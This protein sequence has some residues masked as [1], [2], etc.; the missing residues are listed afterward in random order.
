MKQIAYWM[1][2]GLWIAAVP[3]WG[4]SKSD[5]SDHPATIPNLNGAKRFELLLDEDL[6]R[7]VSSD[8]G[9]NASPDLMPPPFTGIQ[10]TC[11]RGIPTGTIN[12]AEAVT[13]A[14]C[15]DP[16]TRQTWAEAKAQ[17][18]QVGI[19]QAAYLPTA[20]TSLNAGLDHVWQNDKA[21]NDLGAVGSTSGNTNN[22]SLD[23]T[24][25]LFDFGQRAAAVDDAQ[26]TLLAATAVHD[27]TVQTVFLE[28]ASAYYNLISAQNALSIA[29]EVEQFNQ[30]TLADAEA[31]AKQDG[32]MDESEKLQAQASTEQ[33]SLDRNSSEGDLLDT[34]GRL[35]ILLGFAPVVK[36][37]VDDKDVPT[38][39]QKLAH[40]IDELI[41]QALANHPEI[42]AAQA[43][44]NAARA[45]VDAAK[46][47]YLPTLSL[48][49]GNE[50]GRDVWGGKQWENSL[51][52]QMNIPLFNR[53]RHY[54][55]RAALAGLD[56]ARDDVE[57]SRQTVALNVWTAYQS[58]TTQSTAIEH[59]KRLLATARKLLKVEQQLY[60]TG[61]GDMLDL[62]YA[63]Q[64]V[65][66]ASQGQLDA[67][68]NW[69]VAR[70]QL[71]ASLGQLGFWTIRETQG[72]STEQLPSEK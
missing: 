33:A 36:L 55:K 19:E 46:R 3:A 37:S 59:S 17:A 5:S 15:N 61:D 27:A 28:A 70:L 65:A 32:G 42:R 24:W 1:I 12:L 67:L 4:A 35:A 29:K 60:R 71:A 6:A 57:S 26:Q 14:L 31:R 16:R 22:A 48:V 25:M 54:R 11:P 13:R 53:S 66:D 50:R 7:V 62:L 56:S 21:A 40:S 68:T 38:P 64:T 44:V 20:N 51:A 2:C 69:R 52:L 23:F 43:R 58:L 18:A 9:S 45:N 49:Q 41:K 8:D 34:Q 30:R 72:A 63:Q 47:A 10:G 39:D